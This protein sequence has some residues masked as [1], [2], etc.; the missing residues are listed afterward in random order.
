MWC[1]SFQAVAHEELFAHT[2]SP[3]VP[4]RVFV[5]VLRS[6]ALRVLD[7]AARAQGI[8]KCVPVQLCRPCIPPDCTVSRSWCCSR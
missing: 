6:C 7:L 4:A 3:R 2:H 5:S 8:D 1:V